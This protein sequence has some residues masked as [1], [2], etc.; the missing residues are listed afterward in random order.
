MRIPAALW[1]DAHYSHF[2]RGDALHPVANLADA[3]HPSAHE[4]DERCHWIR[5][6]RHDVKIQ[7]LYND[8]RF[9]LTTCGVS[10]GGCGPLVEVG[11]LGLVVGIER[12]RLQVR[13]GL[14]H[15]C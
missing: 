1:V 10:Q 8:F 4:H 13:A 9:V 11:H 5:V 6:A 7:F 12:P 2:A 3:T 14:G 15:A